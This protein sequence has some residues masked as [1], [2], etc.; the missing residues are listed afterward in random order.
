MTGA[1]P[2]VPGLRLETNQGMILL[3]DGGGWRYVYHTLKMCIRMRA[4]FP[5]IG[6][7]LRVEGNRAEI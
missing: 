4:S 5:E 7:A 1:A 6:S 3:D 2:S